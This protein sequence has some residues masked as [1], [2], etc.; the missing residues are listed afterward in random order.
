MQ[1]K[2]DTETKIA[3]YLLQ[4][5]AIKLSPK[6]PFIWASGLKSPIY[7][8]NRLSLSHPTIRTDIKKALASLVKEKYPNVQAIIGV[9]TAGIAPGALV[10][11][12]L[13]LPF[14]YVRSEAKKHGMGKQVEGDIKPGDRVVVIEDLVST[15]KSSLQAIEALRDFGVEVLGLACIFTYGFNTATQNFEQA[16][17]PYFSLSNYGALVNVAA[18]KGYITIPEQQTL[19]NWANDPE[20]W[21]KEL[22]QQF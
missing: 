13:E 10:A 5:K 21:S 19:S 1:H 17:C 9:A 8:D 18:E 22:D 2:I 14:G 7:S 20:K 12:E 15:G 3:E 4:I 6:Q 16:Q 11:D